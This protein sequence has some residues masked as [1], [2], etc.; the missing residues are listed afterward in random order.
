[1]PKANG[2][3]VA[4][5]EGSEADSPSGPGPVWRKTTTK[6]LLLLNVAQIAALYTIYYNQPIVVQRGLTLCNLR[7]ALSI[8]WFQVGPQVRATQFRSNTHDLV[9]FILPEISGRKASV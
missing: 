5:P 9:V 6:V 3:L 2:D 7:Q 4:K 1:M 8:W